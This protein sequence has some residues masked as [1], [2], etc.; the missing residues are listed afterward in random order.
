LGRDGALRA[1]L[2]EA[3]QARAEQFSTRAADA[4]LR[5]LYAA[6]ARDKGL[7]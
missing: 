4:R 3:A 7:R 5:Q 6:L 2:G 1:K